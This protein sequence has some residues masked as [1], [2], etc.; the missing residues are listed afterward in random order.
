MRAHFRGEEVRG[1]K[2]T[3]TRIILVIEPETETERTL[4]NIY[5]NRV[6]RNGVHYYGSKK[7][8]GSSGPEHLE[9]AQGLKEDV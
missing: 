5:T 3:L 8:S 1:H 6:R 4:L 2:R 9:L 7:L